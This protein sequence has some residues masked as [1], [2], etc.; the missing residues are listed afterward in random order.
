MRGG[1]THDDL[2]WEASP[3]L[4][5]QSLQHR[6]HQGKGSLAVVA[7]GSRAAKHVG[8]PAGHRAQRAPDPRRRPGHLAGRHPST[9]SIV[10]SKA[11]LLADD[12]R[13]T[14][15]TSTNKLKK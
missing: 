7:A 2:S 10:L 13:I 15:P 4:K 6:W 9:L 3:M 11:F 14:E 1:V 5:G 12:A 8:R